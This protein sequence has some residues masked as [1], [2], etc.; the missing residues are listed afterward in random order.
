MPNTSIDTRKDVYISDL[1]AFSLEKEQ[2]SPYTEKNKW[3]TMSYETAE[4]KGKMLIASG[5]STPAPITIRPSLE[6]WYKIYICMGEVAGLPNHIDGKL[7]EPSCG[8]NEGIPRDRGCVR[9]FS[10]GLLSE[11]NQHPFRMG[12]GFPPWG[13]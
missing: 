8:G 3:E 9:H 11:Q 12:V 10:L 7:Y 13:S 4:T 6:G 2:I 1:Y 5:E